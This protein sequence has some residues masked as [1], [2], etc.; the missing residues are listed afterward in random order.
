MRPPAAIRLTVAVLA[1]L[2]AACGGDRANDRSTASVD[3]N[4]FGDDRAVAGTARAVPEVALLE[5]LI[6]DYERLDVVMDELAGPNS[7]SPVQGRAW[8]SD[9]HEDTAK[10]R[11]LDVLQAEYGERYHPR[12]PQGVGHIV[13]SIGGLPADS[14]HRALDALVL[15][16][17]RGVAR[18]IADALPS[19]RNDRVRQVL[20]ELQ[21]HLQDEIRKLSAGQRPNPPS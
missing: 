7:E 19:V 17:H 13:D 8:K 18:A 21:E 4:L 10:A 11:L 2:P 20:A 15:S 12:T 3:S 14:G 5:R 1:M 6:D 16:H 9:R